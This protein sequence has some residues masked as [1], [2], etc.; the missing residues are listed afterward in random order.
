MEIVKRFLL[1]VLL[2]PCD[3]FGIH[4]HIGLCCQ[5]EIRQWQFPKVGSHSQ[6]KLWHGVLLFDKN[7]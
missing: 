3:M 4:G 6:L 5:L 2:S 1:G 7:E